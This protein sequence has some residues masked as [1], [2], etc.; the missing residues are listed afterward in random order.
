[1]TSPG[2]PWSPSGSTIE[3]VI[4]SSVCATTVKFLCGEV[5]KIRAVVFRPYPV[6]SIRPTMQGVIVVVLIGRHVIFNTVYHETAVLDTIRIPALCVVRRFQPDCGYL[7]L[8]E[9]THLE[10]L[11]SEDGKG[12]RS[13]GSRYQSRGQY[14]VQC[15]WYH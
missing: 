12:L 5:S 11:Q 14:P 9:L 1:M 4:E 15:H 7:C 8:Q 3:K 13:S 2:K 10:L 6:P